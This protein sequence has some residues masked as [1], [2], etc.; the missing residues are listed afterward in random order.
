MLQVT[1]LDHRFI[2]IPGGTGI[3]KTRMGWESKHLFFIST[4]SGDTA[5]FIKVLKNNV[6]KYI[7]GF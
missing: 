2:L 7:K 4:R 6:S 5:E 1:R 3:G